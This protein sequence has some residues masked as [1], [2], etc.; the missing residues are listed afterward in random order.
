MMRHGL[1]IF[2]KIVLGLKT[3]SDFT[4]TL[5]AILK[6]LSSHVFKIGPPYT[7]VF[8]LRYESPTISGLGFI[9]NPGE[10]VWFPDIL[11]PHS[12]KF[13]FPTENAIN[14]E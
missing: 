7:S 2:T 14:E 9:L 4:T 10:S 1:S 13:P 5:P 6:G 11:N 12:F 3:F 8:N